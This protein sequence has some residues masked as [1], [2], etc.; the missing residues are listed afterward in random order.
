MMDRCTDFR[1]ESTASATEAL[2]IPG[3]VDGA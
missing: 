3:L 1:K 2:T